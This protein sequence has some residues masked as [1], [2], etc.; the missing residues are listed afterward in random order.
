MKNWFQFSES[1]LSAPY[2]GKFA[3]WAGLRKIAVF[4]LQ[5]TTTWQRNVATLYDQLNSS[6]IFRQMLNVLDKRVCD[7]KRCR[8]WNC[9]V[10]QRTETVWVVFLY[11]LR[12]LTY[13]L[14][15]QEERN[16]KN[17]E[18]HEA[19]DI[20]KIISFPAYPNVWEKQVMHCDAKL[21][22]DWPCRC[23]ATILSWPFSEKIDVSLVIH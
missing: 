3:F 2:F 6:W 7:A 21:A 4:L 20:F 18:V 12:L 8:S 5:A 9:F 23:V 22:S 10:L 19:N 11:L 15:F 1:K 17:Y 13:M 16:K 14:D